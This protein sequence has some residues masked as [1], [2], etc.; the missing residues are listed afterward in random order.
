MGEGTMQRE[1]KAT[2][3]SLLTAETNMA[4]LKGKILT[5]MVANLNNG[6]SLSYINVSKH[7]FEPTP[8]YN[9]TRFILNL[10]TWQSNARYREIRKK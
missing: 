6:I 7:C 1:Y 10:G 2:G 5:L 9:K 8:Q 3:R 4:A